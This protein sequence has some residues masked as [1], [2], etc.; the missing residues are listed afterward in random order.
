MRPS[1]RKHK[2]VHGACERKVCQEK[3]VH[4]LVVRQLEI[5]QRALKPERSIVL[6][7]I[8]DLM[9]YKNRGGFS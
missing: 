4:R 7:H 2:F 1:N 9:Q 5:V 8:I 6:F 3:C